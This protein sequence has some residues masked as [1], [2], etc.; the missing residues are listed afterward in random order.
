[1]FNRLRNAL[2]MGEQ[3]ADGKIQMIDPATVRRWVEAGEVLLID[4]RERDEFAAERIAGSINMPLS[5]FDPALVPVPESGKRLV[6]HCRSGVRCGTAS[7]YLAQAGYG[8][9]IHRMQG[10]ILGWKA[11]GG[12]TCPGS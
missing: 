11:V 7:G 4:V 2:G 3:S 5:S 6:I 9:D 10:G 1:M 12:P 8:G